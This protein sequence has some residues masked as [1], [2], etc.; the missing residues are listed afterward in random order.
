M[1]WYH[2]ECVQVTEQPTG[3]WLCPSCSPS[4]AFYIKQLV[5]GRAAPSPASR[6]GKAATPSSSKE[7]EQEQEQKP[8]S[9]NENVAKKGIATKKPSPE[10]AHP[11]SSKEKEHGSE[12]KNGKIAK[13]GLAIKKPATQKEKPKWKGYVEVS[14]DGEEEYKKKVEAG[15]KVEDGILGKRT[16]GSKAVADED[17]PRSRR[18]RTR[19]RPAEK[20]KVIE[21]DSEEDEETDSEKSLYQEKEEEMDDEEE[22]EQEE[23]EEE[24]EEAESVH[25]KASVEDEVSD[26]DEESQDSMEVDDR[27]DHADE[28]SADEPSNSPSGSEKDSH[29]SPDPAQ[30]R[31]TFSRE[32]EGKDSEIVVDDLDDSM[33]DMQIG[34]GES[35]E[36]SGSDVS[37]YFSASSKTHAVSPNGVDASNSSPE[38]APATSPAGS[39]PASPREYTS[40]SDDSMET[41]QDDE[42][43]VSATVIPAVESSNYAALYQHQWNYWGEYPESAVRSTLPRL[44]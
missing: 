29:Y 8:K 16:R 19:L 7:K 44:G 33:D 3:T 24:E 2:W 20:R 18:L 27:A 34:Q 14:S 28:D 17:E 12:T 41:D 42:G 32:D 26:D 35:V 21:T 10:K 36:A 5:K 6:S 25:E 30:A 43:R 15:W 11:L 22:E 23:E 13:K 39:S 40:I 1:S 38:H 9:P 4:A 37:E 31:S